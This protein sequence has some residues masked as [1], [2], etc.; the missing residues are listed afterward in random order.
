MFPGKFRKSTKSVGL[1]VRIHYTRI[2]SIRHFCK[3]K[4]IFILNS[5]A[6][7]LCDD[8]WN[9][10]ANWPRTGVFLSEKKFFHF[11][12]VL[13]LVGKIETAVQW[14]ETV[15]VTYRKALPVSEKIYC[16]AIY[17][18]KRSNEKWRNSHEFFVNWIVLQAYPTGF[19]VRGTPSP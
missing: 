2:N 4:Q 8:R 19:M 3:A 16:F 1:V 13:N 17:F 12:I 18:S 10:A 7:S 5:P 14:I 15:N 9:K 6:N 11:L